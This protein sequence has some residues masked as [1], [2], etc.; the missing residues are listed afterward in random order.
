MIGGQ[1]L[2][3][4]VERRNLL[5]QLAKR[6][7]RQR[8]IG[9][10]AGWLW[11]LVHPLVMLA[12]WTFVF[13]YC[14]Q[15]D[16]P[17]GALTKNYTI[18]LLTGYLPW[19]LFQETVTRSANSLLEHAN[20]ITK[21]L[22]PS[23]MLPISVFFS[24][25]ANHLLALSLSL[26]AIAYWEGGLSPYTLLLPL[27]MVMIGFLGVGIG[28]VFA[29]LQVYVR[30]TAQAVMV[31]LTFWF[32]MTPIF[33]TEDK[34]PEAMRFLIHGNPMS[35]FVRAYRERLLSPAMP[36]WNELAVLAAWSVSAFILGG[37]F[38]RHLKR[39]FADVL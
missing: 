35:L 14:M 10:A 33:I 6:D 26:A 31:L 32:W 21:T 39:G 29:S 34:I 23:E 38:F 7:F 5:F 2:R 12:S 13:Q 17:P 37:L 19:M 8:Y 9:S 11:G 22:F 18:F 28:W 25:L 15:S 30:D 27:Y 4:L 3:N 20:L 16:M 1:F 24:S 36:A